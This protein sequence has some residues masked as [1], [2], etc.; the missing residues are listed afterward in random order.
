MSKD[1]FID[2]VFSLALG[3]H[4]SGDYRRAKAAYEQVLREQPTHYLSLGNLGLLN[5][6]MSKIAQARY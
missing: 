4:Q 1:Y 2:E 3:Y 6:Q 5:L